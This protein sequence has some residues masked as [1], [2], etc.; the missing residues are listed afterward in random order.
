MVDEKIPIRLGPQTFTRMLPNLAT[1]I[2]TCS[3]LSAIRFALLNDYKLAAAAIMVAGIFDAMDGRLARLLGAAS[4]FG[5]ELDSLSDFVSFGVAPPVVLYI[6]TMH[7]WRG[8]GWSICLFFAVCMSLRLAR[9]NVMSR[10][11][12]QPIWSSKF[13]T[14]VPAPAAAMIGLFPMILFL[15]TDL[16][17]LISP[18]TCG[19]FLLL[20]GCLMVSRFPTFS[21][22]SVHVPSRWV[23]VTLLITGLLVAALL[24][25]PWDTLSILIFG[26]IVSIP[27]SSLAFKKLIAA[28][29]NNES[30]KQTT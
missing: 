29:H 5:A 3:G 23:P 24:N 14:G 9:F 21:L 25:A 4:D 16:E 18:I 1:M 12:Q 26:Y 22:K 20:S 10:D 11:T 8:F 2:A 27:F 6:L 17:F 30:I 7:Q 19:F 13:F 15:A 28:T